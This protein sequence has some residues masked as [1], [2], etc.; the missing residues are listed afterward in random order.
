VRQL[1]WF[2]AA[3]LAGAVAC[4]RPLDKR[5]AAAD[6]SN[7]PEAAS[8]THPRI[9]AAE[10]STGLTPLPREPLFTNLFVRG[11][12]D[13]VVS[14]P[15]G[16]TSL[17]P[18]VVVLHG[19]GDR[20]DWNC[21]AW[22]HITGAYGFVVC[23]RGDLDA[24]SST[25]EDKRYTLR[26][27]AYLRHYIDASLDALAERYKSY[28]L[29]E[30]TLLTGFSLG[31]TEAV[32]LA[33]D[34]PGRFRRLALLEGGHGAWTPERIGRFR[35][36]GGERVLF[37]C[38]STWCVAAAKTAAAKLES[39]GVESRVA[40]ANVGHTNDRPL[41]EALM[42]ELGWFLGGDSAWGAISRE[43]GP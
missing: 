30:G 5:T 12:P 42:A 22:R 10:A 18:V 27:G 37:G 1:V 34:D 19:S 14:V 41:Q 8:V 29:A 11:S 25:P 38:G 24:Q 6:L 21:D 32:M 23:P 9:D 15:N 2:F 17:R 13:P 33:V 31:A 39:G 35:A 3:V 28:V 40:H 16:A 4:S 43:R 36:Q 7:S 26:G 20:P